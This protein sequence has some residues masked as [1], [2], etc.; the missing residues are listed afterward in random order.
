L[1]RLKSSS[2]D[3]LYLHAIDHVNPILETLRA[4]NDLHK[5]G[6]FKELGLSNYSAWQVADIWHICNNNGWVKPTV[7]QGMYNVL[8]RTIEKELF[9]A[10]RKFGLRFYS[11]NPLAGGILTGRYEQTAP[12]EE[13]RFAGIYK[14]RYWKDS[15]FNAREHITTAIT[16]YN[17]MTGGE[18]T[19]IQ[20]AFSWL[21][22]HSC[23]KGDLGDG[24]ILGASKITHLE[25]NLALC[26]GGTTLPEEIL[27][28]CDE[29]WSICGKDCPPYF[30]T[31]SGQTL[32]YYVRKQL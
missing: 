28:A 8:T 3:L 2:V 4:C 9:L 26:K 5:E 30:R 13:G 24:I 6:K 14:E 15:Y 7:Y 22:Y 32:L 11:Y 10:I 20:V 29:A 19:L 31:E 17:Q 1:E 25:A 16:K 18:L 27:K 23:L 21:L 12:P